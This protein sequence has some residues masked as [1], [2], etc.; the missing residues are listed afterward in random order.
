MT[1]IVELV[2]VALAT[3][4]GV[5]SFTGV[6]VVAPGG[7]CPVL[8][9]TRHWRRRPPRR[10]PRR[11]RRWGRR[12][13]HLPPCRPGRRVAARPQRGRGHPRG[14]RRCRRR[15][16]RPPW[17]GPAAGPPRAG[18]RPRRPP[19]APPVWARPLR[20]WRR[21]PSSR[22]CGACWCGGP[23][24]CA[25]L[26]VFCF[27]S[28]VCLLLL[29]FCVFVHSFVYSLCILRLFTRGHPR[30]LILLTCHL[31]WGV[32]RTQ[33]D[34]CDTRDPPHR[35]SARAASPRV[36]AHLLHAPAHAAA[37]AC[38]T[39]TS[40]GPDTGPQWPFARAAGGVGG[41]AARVNREAQRAQRARQ[42]TGS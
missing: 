13:R 42:C 30:L 25:C 26:A 1:P 37:G 12:R 22:P 41:G 21:R 2:H 7:R 27:Q 11:W 15:H 28:S 4:I 39:A 5:A 35:P 18:R 14:R 20:R 9:P 36:H 24:V 29:L 16:H 40:P 31:F 23:F 33:D 6:V 8:P 32:A 38:C 17:R 19:R 10:P 34:R 3:L